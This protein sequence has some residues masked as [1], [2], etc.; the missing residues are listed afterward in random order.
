MKRVVFLN[1]EPGFHDEHHEKFSKVLLSQNIEVLLLDDLF[2]AP[3]KIIGCIGHDTVVVGSTG[4]HADLLYKVFVAFL[5]L[6]EQW[7]PQR[8]IFAPNEDAFVTFA[9][10]YPNTLFYRLGYFDMEC[11]ELKYLNNQKGGTS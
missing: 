2:R 7:E 6:K 5:S 8:V 4:L 9:R 1:G 10:R 3:E 11:Y